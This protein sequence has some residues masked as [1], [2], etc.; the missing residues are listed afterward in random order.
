ML[1][2]KKEFPETPG[3]LVYWAFTYEAARGAE[4]LLLLTEC[5]EFRRPD[6][7]GLKSPMELPVLVDGRNLFD[8][9]TVR[10][11][12]FEYISI[13]RQGANP[14]SEKPIAHVQFV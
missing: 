12:G 2:A 4:A 14:G 13:G 6:L 5:D 3:Q 10:R 7:S 11:A 1:N 9:G 8:P